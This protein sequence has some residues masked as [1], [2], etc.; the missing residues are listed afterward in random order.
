MN[1]NSLNRT[2][3][4]SDNLPFL[5][6]LDTESIDLVVIDPPFSKNQTFSGTLKPPLT[7]EESRIERELMASWGVVDPGTAYD[8]GLEYPDES[9]EDAQ[10][11]DIWNF[12]VRVYEDW[13]ERLESV[14]PGAYWLIQSTRYT[15]GDGTAAYIAFMVERM[16]EIRRIL[17]P[18]GSVF[19]HCD[20]EADAYLR[21]MMDAVFGAANFRNQIVWQRAATK[22]GSMTRAL[23]NDADYILWYAKSDRVRLRVEGITTP[24]DM[25]NL[26][27]KTLTKY[28]MKD[29]Q[30]RRIQLTS[31]VAPGSSNGES[32]KTIVFG[33]EVLSP[34]LGQHWRVPGGRKP[35]ESMQGGFNRLW[36]EG[37]LKQASPGALPRYVRYL[38]EQRGRFLNNIWVDIPNINSMAKERTGYPTQKPQALARRIIEAGSQPND[39]VLDCFAGCVREK[40]LTYQWQRN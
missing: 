14:C 12:Q 15:H 37:R 31:I 3:Y 28:S 17:R 13:M 30:G 18:T 9:G 21:Q 26:D 25:E 8:A 35:G 19:L 16:L 33:D 4:I 10:F 5:K 7:S 40:E 11:D 27:E 2:V 20:H 22:K 38:D 24:Y 6:A 1:T 23:A 39:L 29:T 32:G 36:N 34:P